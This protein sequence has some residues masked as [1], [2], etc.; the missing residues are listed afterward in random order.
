ML[1][2]TILDF[3]EELANSYHDQAPELSLAPLYLRGIDEATIIK[4]FKENVLPREML[5]KEHNPESLKL[6][7]KSLN[8]KYENE[9]RKF[10]S[11][12]AGMDPADLEIMWEWV[13]V[14]IDVAKKE[15]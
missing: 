1:K 4:G 12:V 11:M 14:I 9:L 5:F 2:N 3:L 13:D 8:F 15:C 10:D 6:M 7:F